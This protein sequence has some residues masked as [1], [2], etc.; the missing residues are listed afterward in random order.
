MGIC[1]V[2]EP[3]FKEAPTGY[4]KHDFDLLDSPIQHW[5]QGLYQK[6][7]QQIWFN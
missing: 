3:I 7:N 1:E 2:G 6:A 5:C 4:K